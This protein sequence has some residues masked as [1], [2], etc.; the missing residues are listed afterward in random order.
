MPLRE[1]AS[2]PAW[3]LD[4]LEHYLAREPAPLEKLEIAIAHLTAHF[5]NASFKVNTQKKTADMLLF[6]KA[7]SAVSDDRYNEVDKQVL[8]EL[9]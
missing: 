4:L 8:A 9:I 2:W 3:E 1:V 6:R 7:W 5:V